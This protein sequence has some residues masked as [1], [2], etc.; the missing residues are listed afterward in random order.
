[1]KY[2]IYRASANAQIFMSV[3]KVN[4]NVD[5]AFHDSQVEKWVRDYGC[6]I[7][8][9][10][11]VWA[12]PGTIQERKRHQFLQNNCNTNNYCIEETE[13]QMRSLTK[14]QISSILN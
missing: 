14:S 11:Q 13:D 1:M 5:D 7:I 2:G 12:W 6:I 8:W 4:W 3:D 10:I 9:I